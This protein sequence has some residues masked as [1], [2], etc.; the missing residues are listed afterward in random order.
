[1]RNEFMWTLVRLDVVKVD[2]WQIDAMN[3]SSLL[4]IME[5]CL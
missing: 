5:I 3:A 1:M 2:A 4:A